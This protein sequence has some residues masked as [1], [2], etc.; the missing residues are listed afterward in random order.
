V[1]ILLILLLSNFS[2]SCLTAS[3]VAKARSDFEICRKNAKEDCTYFKA[4]LLERQGNAGSAMDLYLRAGYFDDFIRLKALSGQDIEPLL[5][6]HQ[7]GK[8]KGQYYR[9]ILYFSKGKW[10]DAVDALSKRVVSNYTPARFYTAYSYIMMGQVNNAKKILNSKPS[11]LGLEDELYYNKLIGII[12][13]AENKQ[14]EALRVFKRI[15]QK[16]PEDFIALKYSAHIYYR[17]GWFEKAEK[18]YSNLLAKEWRDTDLYYLLAERCEMRARYSKFDLAERD[19]KKIIKEFPQRKD[20]VPQFMSWL[21]EYS[22]IDLAKKYLKSLSDTEDKYQASLFYFAQAL[23]DSFELKDESALENLKKAD[24]A[25]PSSEYKQRIKEVKQDM[26]SSPL[27]DYPRL[28]CKKFNVQRASDEGIFVSS[29]MFGEKWPIRYLIA[30]S[31]NKYLVSLEL[32]FKYPEEIN[33]ASHKASWVSYAEKTWSTDG[34]VLKVN[35]FEGDIAPEKAIAVNIAP[36]PSAFYIQRTSSH[37][38]NILNPPTVVAHE[39]GHLMGLDDEYYETDARIYKRT[40]D[41]FI[42]PRAS[43]MRNVLSGKP[44]KMHIHFILSPIKCKN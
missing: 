16:N 29:N 37:Q 21:L 23:I 15:L 18:I 2:N 12:L 41:R 36:W 35:S 5:K 32:A 3:T 33:F 14:L 11:K 31:G 24:A 1:L 43:I 40:K 8:L 7:I 38:W 20:F 22:N 6:E 27:N 17:T 34:L 4:L 30:H 19:A 13:Y 25:Y 26:V 42:G 9:G 28:E 39:I 44:Q 10:S